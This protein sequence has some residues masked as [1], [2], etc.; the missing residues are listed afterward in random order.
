M[1]SSK[2]KSNVG[3]NDSSPKEGD[4]KAFLGAGSEFEG[5][6]VFNENMRI[7]GSFRGEISSSDLLVVGDSARL[8]AE[9]VVG[10]LI[11]S[12]HFQGNISAKNRVELRAPAQINGNVEAPVVSIEEG[13]IFNGSIKMNPPG[14]AAKAKSNSDDKPKKS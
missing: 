10:S 11:I 3:R 12:G 4:V 9:V 8:Q 5:R 6:M 2:E 14:K 13:V 7:D 1:F